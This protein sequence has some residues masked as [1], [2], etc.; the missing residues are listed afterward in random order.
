MNTVDTEFEEF[1]GGLWGRLTGGTTAAPGKVYGPPS[2]GLPQYPPPDTESAM[3]RSAIRGGETNENALADLVFFRRHPERNGRLISRSESNFAQL[4]S[5]WLTIRDTLV[6]PALSGTPT[7]PAGGSSGAPSAPGASSG[8]GTFDGKPVANWFIPYLTWARQNGW[9]G[10]LN[11]GY[12]T[13][14]YSEQLCYRICQPPAPSCPGR[15]AGRSSSHSQDVKPKGAIDVSDEARFGELMAR[16]PFSP[17]I[18]NDLPN[19]RIHFSV[20]GH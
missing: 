15:C 20:T 14:E 18:C 6:R 4:S 10:R 17:R 11:S 1:L 19:D 2:P 13:P 7:A 5:E 3:L 9:Q 8:V 12:R 16:C